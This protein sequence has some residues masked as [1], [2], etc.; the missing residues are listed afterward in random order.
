MTASSTVKE[1]AVEA[2]VFRVFL[3]EPAD[4]RWAVSCKQGGLRLT[5]VRSKAAEHI[6]LLFGVHQNAD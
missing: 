4:L 1:Q 2:A 6:S 5:I 3:G